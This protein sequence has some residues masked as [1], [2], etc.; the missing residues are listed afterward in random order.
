[1]RTFLH[2]Q[3]CFTCLRMLPPNL[4]HKFTREKPSESRQSSLA[5]DNAVP[6]SSKWHQ[7]SLM[8][9]MYTPLLLRHKAIQG[10]Q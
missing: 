3:Q 5:I 1:M 8:P 6:T 2:S 7:T 10:L 4:A 9:L